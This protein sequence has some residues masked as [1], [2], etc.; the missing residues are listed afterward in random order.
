MPAFSRHTGMPWRC[1]PQWLSVTFLHI[2]NARRS[3]LA[4]VFLMVS[5]FYLLDTSAILRMGQKPLFFYRSQY[6][7]FKLQIKHWICLF[8]DLH[9]RLSHIG[10]LTTFHPSSPSGYSACPSKAAFA[11]YQ[12]IH[13]GLY[14]MT[15]RPGL[16]CDAADRKRFIHSKK[17]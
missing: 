15:G 1:S 5:S 12:D 13:K 9:N 11:L 10:K 3:G 14:D 8:V 6:R 16:F 7:L 2:E 4:M 17:F